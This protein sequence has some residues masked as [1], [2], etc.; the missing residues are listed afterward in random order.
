M[1]EKQASTTKTVPLKDSGN[2]R[3]QRG[4]GCLWQLCFSRRRNTADDPEWVLLKQQKR[5][6][7]EGWLKKKAKKMKEISEVLARPNLKNFTV[8]FDIDGMIKKKK[9]QKRSSPFYYDPRSYAL[10]FDDGDGG[11]SGGSGSYAGFA[12]R[13][14]V[15][16][17]PR[18]G[19]ALVVM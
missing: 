8:G 1:D 19:G 5:E 6:I 10:N 9:N 2:V 12:A 3:D 13:F 4:R 7:K 14:A 18:D 17:L 16:Q 15:P 11:E